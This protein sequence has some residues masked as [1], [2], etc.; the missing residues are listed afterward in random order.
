[1]RAKIVRIGNSQGVRIPRPL[2]EQAGLDEQVELHVEG[3]TIVIRPARLAREGWSSAFA[4][5]SAA[6]DDRLLDGPDSTSFDED[7]WNW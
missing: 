5:M 7:E 2:I 4:H 6:G 3:E 1:M